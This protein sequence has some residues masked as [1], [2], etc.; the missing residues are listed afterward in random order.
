MLLFVYGNVM[1]ASLG[2]YIAAGGRQSPL[3]A[4]KSI[5]RLPLIYAAALALG[6]NTL[7]VPIPA[8]VLDAADLIGKAGPILAINP[9]RGTSLAH[10]PPRPQFGGSVRR[11]WCQGPVGAGD[12]HRPDAA[13]RRGG[14]RCATLLLL[15]SCLP[16]AINA[17][18]LTVRFDARPDLLGGILIGS[19]LWSPLGLSILLYW[20]GP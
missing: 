11:H 6:V 9:A 19:T 20:I 10:P 7:A 4:F 12:W 14:A 16:T 18:I 3:Q 5:F 2:T 13:H 17:L 1:A 8:S 15:C